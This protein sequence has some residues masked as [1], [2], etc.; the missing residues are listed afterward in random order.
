MDVLVTVASPPWIA[1]S[2]STLIPPLGAVVGILMHQRNIQLSAFQ[3]LMTMVA[4]RGHATDTVGI[5]SISLKHIYIHKDYYYFVRHYR[6]I[7]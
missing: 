3:R 4:V 7:N 1:P 5:E 2:P 6:N